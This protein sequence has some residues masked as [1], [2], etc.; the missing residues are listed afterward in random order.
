MRHPAV[1]VASLLVVSC[2]SGETKPDFGYPHDDVLRINH[3]QMK[4]THNSY[5]LRPDNPA[6][7][8]WDYSHATLT[9][10]LEKQGVRQFELDVHYKAEEKRFEVYHVPT[11]DD[12]ST[13]PVFK[14]CLRELL[15]WSNAHPGHH[16]LFVFLEPKDDIDQEP[17]VIRGHYD[18]LDAEILSV[19]GRDRI[20]TPDDVKGSFATLKEAVLAQRWPTLAESRGK[21][22]FVFLDG[23]HTP[24][25]HQYE[26]THGN[27]DLNGRVMFVYSD[28]TS[29]P[30]SAILSLQNPVRDEAATRQAAKDGF[31]VRTMSDDSVEARKDGVRTELDAALSGAAHIISTDFPIETTV[32]GYFLDLKDGTPTRCNPVSAPS[33]CSGSAIESADRLRP[34]SK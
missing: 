28:D 17:D 9:E 22:L 1:I 29:D 25:S 30:Y 18:E 19:W 13:C 8:E 14:D 34:F 21:I 4:G 12:R 10:Q 3:L 5:H 20:I 32:P 2:T 24:G 27:K 11:L 16:P 26:Y 31:I 6:S 15:T 23:D 7:P 33:V